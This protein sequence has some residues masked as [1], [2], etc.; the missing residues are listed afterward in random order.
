M[1]YCSTGF[2]KH[3]LCLALLENHK[4]L[5]S[6]H[7]EGYRMSYPVKKEAWPLVRVREPKELRW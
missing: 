4:K 2:T 7:G 5:N 6:T 1:T 3:H